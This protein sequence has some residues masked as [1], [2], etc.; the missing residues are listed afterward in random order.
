M[1]ARLTSA[2]VSRTA[3]QVR[4]DVDLRQVGSRRS[5]ARGLPIES[6]EPG[7]VVAHEDVLRPEVAMDQNGRHGLA[8]SADGVPTRFEAIQ[9]FNELRQGPPAHL[10]QGPGIAQAPFQPR[11][12]ANEVG[13]ISVGA[14][15]R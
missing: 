1:L 5:P 3:A 2:H 12:S 14:S 9:L 6:H 10:I 4:I 8:S 13:E 11:S 7:A 15:V